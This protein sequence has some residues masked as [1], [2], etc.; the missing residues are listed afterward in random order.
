[1]LAGLGLTRGGSY[2]NWATIMSRVVLLLRMMLPPMQ[3]KMLCPKRSL[4]W[5][6]ARARALYKVQGLF[7]QQ[8]ASGGIVWSVEN[9]H[10]RHLFWAKVSKGWGSIWHLGARGGKHESTSEPVDIEI[11][12]EPGWDLSTQDLN[13]PLPDTLPSKPPDSGE[14]H[15]GPHTVEGVWVSQSVMQSSKGWG[16]QGKHGGTTGGPQPVSGVGMVLLHKCLYTRVS[17]SKVNVQSLCTCSRVV[18]KHQ[19]IT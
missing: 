13:S 15:Q 7:C 6:F 18:W 19:K 5:Q 1:M 14:G 12:Q 10:T 11:Q 3:V 4:Q 9:V 16:H 2:V 8:V 17:L